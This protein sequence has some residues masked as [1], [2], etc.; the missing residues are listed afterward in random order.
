MLLQTGLRQQHCRAVCASSWGAAAAAAAAARRGQKCGLG[1]LLGP[2]LL[3]CMVSVHVMLHRPGA[4][5]R[6]LPCLKSP[7]RKY[8]PLQAAPLLFG[9]VTLQNGMP[10]GKLGCFFRN[11]TAWAAPRA[12]RSWAF[13]SRWRRSLHVS[14]AAREVGH[15]SG[16]SRAVASMPADSSAAIAA[17]RA[18]WPH[19]D[20][21]FVMQTRC[22]APDCDKKHR[23]NDQW[24]KVAR[25]VDARCPTC[26]AICCNSVCQA[27]HVEHNQCKTHLH[28]GCWN[29]SY[30]EQAARIATVRAACVLADA[31][32][33]PAIHLLT[34]LPWCLHMVLHAYTLEC[35]CM[36][37][38]IR[39]L[40]HQNRKASKKAVKASGTKASAKAALAPG[41][42]GPCGGACC[43]H[44][45]LLCC[46]SRTGAAPAGWSEDACLLAAHTQ[47]PPGR[48]MHPRSP[49][50]QGASCA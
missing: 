10:D 9:F 23:V 25:G 5:G 37:Q 44:A 6:A 7:A 46:L 11:N 34:S 30:L 22:Q 35:V 47:H 4:P 32:H 28:T 13:D 2:V 20:K 49:Q 42:V 12:V 15:S 1:C 24:N 36:L 26:Y 43:G 21:Q 3:L 16:C 41:G 45:S 17:C 48:A 29:N 33:L 19:P 31:C 39:R 38:E 27:K 18:S 8:K 40:E 14:P 50:G